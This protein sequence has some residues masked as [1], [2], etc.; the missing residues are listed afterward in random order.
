MGA[1]AAAGA[2]PSCF[3]RKGVIGGISRPPERSAS[4][5]WAATWRSGAS[6]ADAISRRA[7]CA[8]SAEGP[9]APLAMERIVTTRPG[10]MFG[11]AGAPAG[12]TPKA[13]HTAMP[14]ERTS[15]RRSLC[16]GAP[17]T[18]AAG[19]P[20]RRTSPLEVTR[21]AAALNPPKATPVSCSAAT[22][23][24]TD[25]PSAAAAGGVKGPRVRIVPSGV[26]SLGS[27][28]TQMPLLSVPHASTGD[29]AGW[30][31]S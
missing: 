3:G 7:L 1:G 15:A 6:S 29:R 4:S 23:E 18:A 10:G 2:A 31:C 14:H 13:A 12:S 9:I 19:C 27:T 26:P 24:S 30:R 22:P 17:R 20:A 25:R 21:T 28:A 8:R 11:G 5:D 16:D